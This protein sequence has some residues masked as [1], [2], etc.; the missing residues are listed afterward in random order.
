MR[1]ARGSVCT[2]VWCLGMVVLPWR[3][4]P[5][6]CPCAH[7]RP[8]NGCSCVRVQSECVRASGAAGEL[9]KKTHEIDSPRH[10]TR[11]R[12]SYASAANAPRSIMTTTSSPRH[13]CQQT[14]DCDLEA[15]RPPGLHCTWPTGGPWRGTCYSR[16]RGLRA[17]TDRA[18]PLR[19]PSERATRR[20][21]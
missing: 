4:P 14:R 9:F 17:W 11:G 19:H 15:R 21:C 6:P 8:P 5:C 2:T 3:T 20:P 10:A 1:V 18:R 7:V 13:V 12:A 16:R